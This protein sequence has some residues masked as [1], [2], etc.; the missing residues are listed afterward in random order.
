KLCK[1]QAISMTISDIPSVVRRKTSLTIRHRFTPA[2][3]CSTMMRTLESRCLRNLSPTLNA[4][5]RGFF[6]AVGSGRPPAH[7]P[8][9]P[10]PYPGCCCPDTR[11]PPHPRLSCHG[12]CQPRWD[13]ERLL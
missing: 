8:E 11:D 5:P 7:S 13:S 3:T 2:I 4:W 9:T 6:W 10:Y 1:P 12:V